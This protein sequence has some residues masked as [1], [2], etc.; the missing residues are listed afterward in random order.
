MSSRRP[1]RPAVGRA[2]R[3]DFFE[4]DAIAADLD[5]RVD[6][7]AV[8][9]LAILIDSTK[10]AGAIDSAGGIVLDMQEITNELLLRQVIAIDVTKR[11]SDARDT[12][13]TDSPVGTVLSS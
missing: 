8:V 2:A 1:A 6:P 5:L 4:L 7:A 12:N 3:F 9:D 13:L 11:Q 10:I